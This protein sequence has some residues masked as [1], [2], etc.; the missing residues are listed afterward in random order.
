M[1]QGRDERYAELANHSISLTQF[2]IDRDM[3]HVDWANRIGAD[4]G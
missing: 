1:L 3:T 2:E 4:H